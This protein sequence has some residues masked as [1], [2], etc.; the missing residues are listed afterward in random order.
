M[1][2]GQKPD[3]NCLFRSLAFLLDVDLSYHIVL[4]NNTVA[5]IC[6]N[7]HTDITDNY[8]V[9]DDGVLIIAEK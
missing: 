6:E 5:W 4:R 8:L 7:I 2:A 3:K 9:R 1:V